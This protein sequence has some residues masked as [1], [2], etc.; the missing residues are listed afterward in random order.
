MLLEQKANL[1]R[2]AEFEMFGISKGGSNSGQ[3]ELI[4]ND[5]ISDK[6]SK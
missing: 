3:K 4:D 2:T 5:E 1:N 6:A